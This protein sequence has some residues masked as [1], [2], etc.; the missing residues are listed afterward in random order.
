VNKLLSFGYIVAFL[1]VHRRDGA[2]DLR[3]DRDRGLGFGRTDH[4]N[5][6]RHRFPNDRS[7]RDEHRVVVSRRAR[8]LYGR[9]CFCTAGDQ[10]RGK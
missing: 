10:R 2:R 7:D 3:V 9:R 5:L 6:E 8:G 1:E 4:P